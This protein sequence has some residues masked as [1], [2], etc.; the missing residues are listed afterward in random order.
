MHGIVERIDDDLFASMEP[1]LFRHGKLNYSDYEHESI[2][3]SMEPCLFRHGKNGDNTIKLLKRGRLQWS[4][5]F[6]DMVSRMRL[7]LHLILV[8]LQWSHVFSDMV[9]KILSRSSSMPNALQWS[10]VFS[11][12][13]SNSKL[14]LP[15]ACGYASMEPCLF[16]HGKMR[17][18]AWAATDLAASMEPCLF[19]HGKRRMCSMSGGRPSALQWSHVFSDMVR[20]LLGR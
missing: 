2:D 14:I 8:G 5:V 3:A 19:R 18:R 6:S 10:H 12:M 4:H 15:L 16:R 9:S 7:F 20:G 17:G 1:C 13:V 11:D